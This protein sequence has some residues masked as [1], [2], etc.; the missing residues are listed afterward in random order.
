MKS[1]LLPITKTSFADAV[2]TATARKRKARASRDTDM[3]I[4]D[5]FSFMRYRYAERPE[6]CL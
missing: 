5:Q 1:T 6:E 3:V 4:E 2:M